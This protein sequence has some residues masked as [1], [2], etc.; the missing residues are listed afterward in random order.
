MVCQI[1]H[2]EQ[3]IKITKRKHRNT[4]VNS[5]SFPFFSP[6]FEFSDSEQYEP[7]AADPAATFVFGQP[8]CKTKI[9][10]AQMIIS[11]QKQKNGYIEIIS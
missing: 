2:D 1:I 5:T 9:D 4:S 11:V 10:L 3:Q 7:S 8:I 6:P